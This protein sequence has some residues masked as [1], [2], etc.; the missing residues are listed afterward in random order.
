MIASMKSTMSAVFIA[1]LLATMAPAIGYAASVQDFESGL[2]PASTT[3]DAQT[4][5]TFEGIAPPQGSNQLLLTTINQTSDSTT[6]LSG[7]GHDAVNV[8]AI[9]AFTGVPTATLRFNATNTGQEG[10]AFKMTLGLNVGD[11]LTFNWDFLTSED[12]AATVPTQD[13]GFA[14]LVLAGTVVNYQ[15]LGNT[16]AASGSLAGPTFFNET[17]N[18]GNHFSTYQ[19]TITQ[20]GTYTLGIGIMDAKNT[21]GP[22]GLLVDNIQVAAVP[23]PSAVGL[24]IAGSVLLVTLRRRI[25]GS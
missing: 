19:F 7:V 13:F 8:A 18:S 24:T 1:A 21:A 5:G 11:V 12:P 14:S 22:S 23:E 6:P 15:T 9:S 10:S 3:G 25:K 17:G 20:A 4:I 2:P 16:T